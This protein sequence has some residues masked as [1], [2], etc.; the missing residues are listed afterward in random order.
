MTTART[1]SP[2]FQITR[3]RFL[4]GFLGEKN[5]GHWWDTSFMN[6]T[7]LRFLNNTFP[8]TTLSAAFV[9]TSEAA[10]SVHDLRIGRVS[11]FHLFRFP[12]ELEDALQVSAG[13]SLDPSCS[14]TLFESGR[15]LDELK[16]VAKREVSAVPGPIQVG[17]V[18][19]ALKPATISAIA[20]HYHA[21]FASGLQ[22]YP[23]F[24]N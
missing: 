9:S 18:N 24:G 17:N 23:Y 11:V 7:G 20:A 21:A 5:Q 10:R 22:S 2:I 13:K 4:V 6:T 16:T 3:L 14:E 12:A 1:S 15:A 19:D 8:R